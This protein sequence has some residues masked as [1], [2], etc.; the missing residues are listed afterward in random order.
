MGGAQHLTLPITDARNGVGRVNTPIAGMEAIIREET[1]VATTLQI[2]VVAV[3]PIF[4]L[5]SC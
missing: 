2:V 1:R 5:R 3:N 4:A